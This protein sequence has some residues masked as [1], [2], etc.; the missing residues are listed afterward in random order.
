[1]SNISKE[2]VGAISD[3]VIAVAATLLV[4]ELKVPEGAIENSEVLL[5]WFRLGTAWLISFMMI[6]AV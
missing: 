2:R 4:L 5:H 3:G 1:M 6:A